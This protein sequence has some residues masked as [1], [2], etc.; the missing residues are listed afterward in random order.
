MK[1]TMLSFQIGLDYVFLCDIVHELQHKFYSQ[2]PLHLFIT[3]FHTLQPLNFPYAVKI[4]V[5]CKQ[6][7]AN[8]GPLAHLTAQSCTDCGQRFA[9][10]RPMAISYL[11][12]QHHT[13]LYVPNI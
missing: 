3:I 13:T 9:N 5:D 6:K 8:K 7:F 1:L 11:V 12:T 2:S 4:Y 10:R